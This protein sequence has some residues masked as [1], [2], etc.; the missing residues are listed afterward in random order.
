MFALTAEIPL[1]RFADLAALASQ[2]PRVIDLVYDLGCGHGE[3]ERMGRSCVPTILHLGTSLNK[4]IPMSSGSLS[5]H[6]SSHDLENL[7]T[8]R[9]DPRF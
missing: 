6:T 3:P 5:G 7:S 4:R 2:S 1:N 9:I 8:C